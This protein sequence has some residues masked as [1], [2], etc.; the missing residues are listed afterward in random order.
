MHAPTPERRV[1]TT[2]ARHRTGEV[3]LIAV[4]VVVDLLVYGG[5]RVTRSGGILPWALVPVLVVAVHSTLLLRW[6]RPGLVLLVQ[7]CFACI[8][9][10]LPDVPLFMGVLVALHAV[11]RTAPRRRS[12][13]ALGG[14]AAVFTLHSV[15]ATRFAAPADRPFA[16]VYSLALWAAFVLAVWGFGRVALRAQQRAERAREARA[17]EV[18]RE[19]RLR[20]A[21]ELHDIIS[22]GVS[23]MLLQAAGARG[24]TDGADPRVARALEVIEGAGSQTM[25]ELH[26]LLGL[27]RA[28]SDSPGGAWDAPRPRL[29]EVPSLVA[30]ACEEG[31]DTHLLVHGDPVPVDPGVDLAGYRLVQEALTN[32]TKHAGPGASVTVELTWGEHL[33]VSVRDTGGGG[34]QRPGVTPRL[35]SGHGLE[36]LAERVTLAGGRL[37]SAQTTNGYL[38]RAE[39]P[40]RAD[41]PVFISPVPSSP[42]LSSPALSGAVDEPSAA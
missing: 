6:R 16:L 20:V 9:L 28:T 17:Q 1:L 12:V 26:R 21:R 24:F 27:L 2:G 33:E 36:G 39:L 7:C 19:E 32:A 11:A 40:V 35:S 31:M 5:D 4:A 13:V 15:N 38:V 22:A 8:G 3:L 29:V 41:G 30:R 23:A 42:A 25:D 14:C 37:E 18:L 34:G 10:L